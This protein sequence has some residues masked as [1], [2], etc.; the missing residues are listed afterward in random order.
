MMLYCLNHR[1][2]LAIIAVAVS[3]LVGCCSC[4]L[5]GRSPEAR[6]LELVPEDVDRI[7]LRGKCLND[8]RD[9]HDHLD[10]GNPHVIRDRDQIRYILQ[11]LQRTEPHWRVH[12]GRTDDG[13]YTDAVE[14]YVKQDPQF[15]YYMVWIDGRTAA[16][17]FDPAVKIMYDK[18]RQ[19]TWK[20][21]TGE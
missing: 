7:E 13:V 19:R 5:G 6:L 12:G 2:R 21:L 4:K 9:P 17:D 3:A 14:I 20:E 1:R 18:Y 16:R 10:I 11:T 8:S 15:A